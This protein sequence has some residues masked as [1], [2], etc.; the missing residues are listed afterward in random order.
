MNAAPRDRRVDA[1]NRLKL[2]LL[3]LNRAHGLSWREIAK[4]GEFGGLDHATLWSLANDPNYVPSAAVARK[5][6]WPAERI[7][8]AAELDSEEQRTAAHELAALYN[9][10]WSQLVTRILDVYLMGVDPLS[11]EEVKMK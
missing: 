3:E 1:H 11:F 10:T 7:R 2:R 8:I 4:L 6:R 5:L 9:C